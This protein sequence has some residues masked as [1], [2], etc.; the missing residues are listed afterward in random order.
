[1]KTFNEFK[2]HLLEKQ[3]DIKKKLKLA[4]NDLDHKLENKYSK[5][6]E[7]EIKQLVIEKKWMYKKLHLVETFRELFFCYSR[8][9]IGSRI[10]LF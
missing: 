1:M 8:Y 9:S 4:L 10:R 3:G 6:K 2:Q 5:L 7:E